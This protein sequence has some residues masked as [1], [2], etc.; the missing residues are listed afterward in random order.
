MKDPAAYMNSTTPSSFWVSRDYGKTFNN[1]S[2]KFTLPNGTRAVITEFYSS[3]A[4]YEN[5]ILVDKFH[6]YIFSSNDE[7]RTF[8]RVSVSFHPVE[9]KYHPKYRNYAL[10]Y[11]KDM[12]NKQVLHFWFLLLFLLITCLSL[13]ATKFGD[14]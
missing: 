2:K 6:K 3:K 12:G 11:E 5:Y 7:C 9:I 8:K 10:A 14:D 4:D 13:L 1:I